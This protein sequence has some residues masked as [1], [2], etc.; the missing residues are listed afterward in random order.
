M[1]AAYGMASGVAVAPPRCW[2]TIVT[3]LEAAESAKRGSFSTTSRRSPAPPAPSL[4]SGQ[5][6][7]S[8]STAGRVTTIGFAR[9]PSAKAATTARYRPV[10]GLRTQ[11]V[12][13]ATARRKKSV[14][15]RSFRSE[16]QATDSTCSGW[17]ANRA[18]TT[19]LRARAP[20]RRSRTTQSSTESTRCQK[21]LA[22]CIHPGSTPNSE[23]SAIRDSQV[24][25]CQFASES[26]VNAHRAPSQVSPRWTTGFVAT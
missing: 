4:P 13:A 1:R 23:T 22:R 2:A 20:V 25:G 15:S 10:E 9:S 26:D 19:Q 12:H 11:A 16:I 7:R 14:E 5:R 6:S 24:S 8:R 18:A 3:R 21:T 17:T